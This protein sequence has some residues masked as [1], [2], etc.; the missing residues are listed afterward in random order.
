[1]PSAH[2][3]SDPAVAADLFYVAPVFDVGGA[4]PVA[5][6]RVL[7]FLALAEELTSRDAWGAKSGH[8]VALMAA[9]LLYDDIL[10]N[11][12]P[13]PAG[14]YAGAVTSES[15]GPI[16]RSFGATSGQGS[17]SFDDESLATTPWGRRLIQMRRS[18][19]MRGVF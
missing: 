10:A 15:V 14:G 7:T 9:H 2:V 11:V 4:S 19:M 16:S 5:E 12:A 3:F 17:G 6:E 13:V 18:L 8:A 1:M